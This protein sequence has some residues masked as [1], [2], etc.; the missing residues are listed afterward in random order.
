[1]RQVLVLFALLLTSSAFADICPYT[2]AGGW[3]CDGAYAVHCSYS[4][5]YEE[6]VE[7]NYIACPAMP[8]GYGCSF[9]SCTCD[10]YC[11]RGIQNRDCSCSCSYPWGGLLCNNCLRPDSD[12]GNGGYINRQ[13][14][15]CA[16]PNT[17]LHGGSQGSN[18]V[19]SCPSPW[20]GQRCEICTR[21]SSECANG[22]YMDSQTCKCVC[23]NTCQN[24]GV[25]D[26]NCGCTCPSPWVG[27]KCESCSL[28]QANCEN[29]STLNSNQCK[30]TCAQGCQNSGTLT[31]TCDCNCPY[32]FIGAVCQTCSISANHC[33][34]NATYDAASCRCDCAN[35]ESCQHGAKR[36][37][38]YSC[39]CDCVN[40]WGGPEC[41]TCQRDAAFCQNGGNLKASSCNCDCS[42]AT[43]CTHGK[44]NER[45]QCLC[46]AGYT[47][48]DCSVKSAAS[49]LVPSL[50]A[51]VTILVCL[52]L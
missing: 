3:V 5:Y 14:C 33:L 34:N 6:Y 31:R 17:C 35:A 8:N 23:P 19:C 12:C 30:C 46:D 1:M 22:G 42:D 40:G 7:D 11:V 36:M 27:P 15:Q 10:N 39:G 26:A 48:V 18:C 44:A 50:M 52:A 9:G 28:T 2:Y 16:C 49:A 32:P 41:A 47:G 45:C 13:N 51:V 21:S 29:G 43:K 37:A 20:A 24:G 25:Q 4:Y 38:D